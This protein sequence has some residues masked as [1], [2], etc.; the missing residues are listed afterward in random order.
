MSNE[1]NQYIEDLENQKTGNRKMVEIGQRL[2]ALCK[3][4]DFRSLILEF[5]MKD[6]TARYAQLSQD[7]AM[8]PEIQK[9]CIQMA[10]A[11]GHFKR[12]VEAIRQQAAV[13]KQSIAEVDEELDRLRSEPEEDNGTQAD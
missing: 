3:N 1:L 9:D 5:W 7:P 6:E 13:A 4:Q 2:E 10:A 12:W 11:S 8:S